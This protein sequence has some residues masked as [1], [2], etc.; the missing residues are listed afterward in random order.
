M[1][2]ARSHGDNLAGLVNLSVAVFNTKL[3]EPAAQVLNF[4]LAAVI[5]KLEQAELEASYGVPTDALDN[6]CLGKS[7]VGDRRPPNWGWKAI[8]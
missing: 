5:R 4:S 6:W 3:V 2:S 7:V 8:V 1:A